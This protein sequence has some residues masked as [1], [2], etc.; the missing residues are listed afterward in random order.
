MRSDANYFLSSYM[1]EEIN[2]LPTYKLEKATG[3]YTLEKSR[4]PSWCD[5]IL[6]WSDDLENHTCSCVLY[7]SI[8]VTGS[9]HRPVLGK[10]VVSILKQEQK[11]A[12]EISS[13]FGKEFRD[14]FLEKDLLS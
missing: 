12:T 5:R 14:T 4:N 1:E 9:D 13:V 7:T 8:N 3:N 11:T 10:F 6:F 2:F